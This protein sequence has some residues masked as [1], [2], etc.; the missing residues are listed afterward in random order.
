SARLSAGTELPC[1]V[2]VAVGRH[3]V[4]LADGSDLLQVHVLSLVAGR[5][6]AA[7][8][9]HYARDGDVDAGRLLA[10]RQ[11]GASAFPGLD[12]AFPEGFHGVLLGSGY[13]VDTHVAAARA[14]ALRLYA[15]SATVRPPL[16]GRCVSFGHVCGLY[17]PA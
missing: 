10:D 2:D 15:V 4:H 5:S 16:L 14:M 3:A 9:D 7:L 1:P 17:L 12:V 6:D 11:R 13:V 8:L